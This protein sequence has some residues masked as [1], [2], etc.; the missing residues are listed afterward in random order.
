MQNTTHFKEKLQ[1]MKHDI[2]LRLSRIEDS[3]SR[4]TG[5][6]EADS[7]EQAK[8][9]QNDEVID[10]LELV[11]RSELQQINAALSRIESGTYGLCTACGEKISDKRLDAL[12]FA[13]ICMNCMQ[14]Q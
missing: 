14:E 2:Q 13:T 1:D 8:T 12:P 4:K 7:E 10:K 5:A 6:L 3:K 9:I 11:E